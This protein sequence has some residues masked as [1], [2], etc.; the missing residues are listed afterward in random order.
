MAAGQLRVAF[1]DE[2]GFSP[3]LPVTW[4]WALPGRRPF[5]PYE[6]P[7]GRRLNVLSALLLEPDRTSFWWMQSYCSLTSPDLLYF[8]EALPPDDL[9]LVVVLDNASIHRSHIIRDARPALKETGITLF[10]LPPYSSA[11]LNDIE[12]YFRALKYYD[13]PERT[14]LTWPEISDAVNAA[15]ARIDDRLLARPPLRSQHELR[16]AA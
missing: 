3:S 11:K 6:N 1:L 8:L 10:Y 16:P 2:V 13:L 7:Q 9:P 15:F 14:Y 12:S 4:S 5:I